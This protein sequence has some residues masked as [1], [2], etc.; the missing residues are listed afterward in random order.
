MNHPH[1]MRDIMMDVSRHCVPIPRRLAPVTTK[2]GFCF[3][4]AVDR[5]G[6]CE[7]TK[8]WFGCHDGRVPS[9]RTPLDVTT[10]LYCLQNDVEHVRHTDLIL[11]SGTFGWLFSRTFVYELDGN[12]WACIGHD[13]VII[14]HAHTWILVDA[15]PCV[16]ESATIV[17]RFI[18][19]G[20]V[21]PLHRGR[22][23]SRCVLLLFL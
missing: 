20:D 13:D 1:D 3:S 6:D 8:H 12:M 16:H 15:R 17:D 14:K 4:C 22:S 11:P 10:P 7:Q 18:N 21:W 23:R 5:V 19:G 9:F 2:K